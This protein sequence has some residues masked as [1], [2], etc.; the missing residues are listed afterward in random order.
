MKLTQ[1][2]R[3]ALTASFPPKKKATT[4]GEFYALFNHEMWR[5]C[6]HCG[7]QFD[8]KKTHDQKCPTCGSNDLRVG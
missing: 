5:T 7:D 1:Q 6:N 8:L 4:M 3:R 2:E